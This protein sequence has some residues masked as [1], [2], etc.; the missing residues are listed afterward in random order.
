MGA[1]KNHKNDSPSLEKYPLVKLI[2]LIFT[3]RRPRQRLHFSLSQLFRSCKHTRVFSPLPVAIL[4]HD[5]E[6]S[7]VGR[8]QSALGTHIGGVQTAPS[9]LSPDS[10][11][12]DEGPYTR[13]SQRGLF[14]YANVAVWEIEPDELVVPLRTAIIEA[15]GPG[16][17][18]DFLVRVPPGNYRQIPE[19]PK[20]LGLLEC[21]AAISLDRAAHVEIAAWF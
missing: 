20:R 12:A 4:G 16:I 6:V 3:P 8:Q 17:E 9:R 21:N 13:L 15:T 2:G 1:A 14:W 19:Q 11:A 5:V 18:R 7:S 10:L